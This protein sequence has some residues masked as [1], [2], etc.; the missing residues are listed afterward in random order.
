MAVTSKV[1]CQ[2]GWWHLPWQTRNIVGPQ[3]FGKGRRIATNVY[4]CCT[5]DFTWKKPI[6]QRISHNATVISFSTN[7]NYVLRCFYDMISSEQW[8]IW[9]I[10]LKLLQLAAVTAW[11]CSKLPQSAIRSKKRVEFIL[12]IKCT[13]WDNLGPLQ[14]Y[15][16]INMQQ[17]AQKV[18]PSLLHLHCPSIC[19]K[20]TATCSKSLRGHLYRQAWLLTVADVLKNFHPLWNKA[21]YTAGWQGQ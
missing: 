2:S 19:R 1:G 12:I 17:P 14:N 13:S 3:F 8:C 4:L 9:P 16:N 6:F 15:Y 10:T 5:N 7:L 21:G 20:Y 18:A 11:I